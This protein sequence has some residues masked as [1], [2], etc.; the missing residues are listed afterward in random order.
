MDIHL[1]HVGKK[2]NREWLFKDINHSFTQ[3][4]SHAI[5]GPNGCGKSTFIQLIAGNQLASSGS[6]HY[7]S[8]EKGKIPAEEVYK[9]MVIT[10]PYLELI[11]EFTLSE[12]IDFHFK[13][14]ELR[15]GVTCEDLIEIGYFEGA[16]NKYIRNF[17]SGMKQRLKLLLAF[18]SRASLVLLDEPTTNL[19][20]TGVDWYQAQVN[21]LKNA[22]ILVA[23]NQ[24][25]EYEFCN[26]Q[27]ALEKFK[28]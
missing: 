6:I 5:I 13:F 1:N 14:K 4:S 7:E 22:L 15:E 16:Q 23:S 25:H 2:F 9:E 19:D 12:A 26:S 27:L 28:P 17:S 3:G 11:E 8:S 21:L 10:A 20:K 24:S 18:Y